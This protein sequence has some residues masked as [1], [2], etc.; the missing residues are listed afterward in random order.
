MV[1]DFYC[2]GCGT[3]NTFERNYI[4]ADKDACTGCGG[5]NRW[6]KVKP[7]PVEYVLS[8]NDKMFLRAMRIDPE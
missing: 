7:E 1:V 4:E 8:R 3:M 6:T 5:K 2:M